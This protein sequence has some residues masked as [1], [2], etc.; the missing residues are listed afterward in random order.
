MAGEDQDLPNALTIVLESFQEPKF[1]TEVEVFT[2]LHIDTFAQATTDGSHPLDWTHIYKKYKKI[3]ED[4]LQRAID[5]AGVEVTAFIEYLA[6][7]SEAYSG[8]PGYEG[9]DAMMTALVT[10]EDYMKFLEIMYALVRE[11][12]EP[13]ES[14]PAPPAPNIQMHCVS[15][16]VPEGVTEGM[17]MSIDYLGL[18][19]QVQVAEGMG[20]G[21]VMNV[22]LE[23]P[24]D[25][26]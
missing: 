24:N 2:N 23:V 13:E 25:S 10:S 9:F 16:T 11:N 3:Y 14:G 17:L 7:C 18:A 20:P 26:N 21:M 6:Q 15:V 8:K 4:Q 5:L 22:T 12:W 19:H 1:V